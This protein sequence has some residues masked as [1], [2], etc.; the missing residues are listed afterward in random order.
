VRDSH[1]DRD[2]HGDPGPGRPGPGV[3]EPGPPASSDKLN[4]KDRDGHGFQRPGTWTITGT[5]SSFDHD[6]KLDYRDQYRHGHGDR[7]DY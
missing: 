1:R 7:H 2:S 4:L 6:R 5:D 3:G